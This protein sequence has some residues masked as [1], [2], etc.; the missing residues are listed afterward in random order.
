MTLHIDNSLGNVPMMTKEKNAK[1]QM[2]MDLLWS[3]GLT[4]WSIQMLPGNP[5]N[6]V[7]AYCHALLSSQRLREE[8]EASKATLA[9]VDL[10]YN[11]CGLAL[12]SNMS[13]PAVGYWA[14]SFSS[15]EAEMSAASTP[16]S[17]VPVFL[18]ELPD[19]M[20][21]WQRTANVGNKIFARYR[22]N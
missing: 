19:V 4:L 18:S 22:S 2:P 20:N 17:H 1:F 14:F 12:A 9:L 3:N 13:L 11:E 21:F 16:P 7:Q 5:W 10:I 6:L 8:I 15:G